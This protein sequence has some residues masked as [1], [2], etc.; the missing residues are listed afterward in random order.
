[1]AGRAQPQIGARLREL[2]LARN[3]S[4]NAVAAATGLS[5]SSLSMTE[6]GKSDITFGRL[7]HLI[8]YY[9]VTFSELI[10]ERP[11][12]EPVVVR[13]GDRRALA[14]PTEGIQV[15]LLT[16]AERHRLQPVLVTYEPEGELLDYEL[17]A[18]RE[19]FWLMLDGELELGIDD[20]DTIIVR[21]GD[22]VLF[23][24]SGRLAVRNTGSERATFVAVG[25]ADNRLASR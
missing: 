21:P 17:E 23:D 10:P 2:R 18:G 8:D 12:A 9:G 15:H 22:S 20:M 19:V 1:M 7:Q 5:A 11:P 24:Q 25:L 6:N 3:L 13:A 4:L 14:S 16:H